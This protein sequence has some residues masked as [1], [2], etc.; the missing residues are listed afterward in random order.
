M[1][2]VFALLI[3]S[4]LLFA[5][6]ILDNGPMILGATVILMVI[7][8]ACCN[9]LANM[10]NM[11][12]LEAWVKTEVREIIIAGILFA[13]VAAI[14]YPDI[15]PI[16]TVLTAGGT[17]D[18]RTDINTFTDGMLATL[19]QA[20]YHV[21]KMSHYFT[22]RA[23]MAVSLNI[24]IYY[25]GLTQSG[26]PGAGYGAF[27]VP[28]SHAA[29]ALSN[30][31]Y[32]YKIIKMLNDFFLVICPP[33]LP[34]A[35][36]FRFIPFTRQLGNT[37]IALILGAYI[38]Y[39]ASIILVKD[40]HLMIDIPTPTVSDS[41]YGTM[42]AR[43]PGIEGL[44]FIC[45]RWYMRLLAVTL[46]ELGLDIIVC[47]PVAIA[48]LGAGWEPCKQIIENI[49]WPI[50]QI[51]LMVYMDIELILAQAMAGTGLDEM[52]EAVFTFSKATTQL[53]LV[54]YIDA[55]IIGTITISGTRSIASALGGEY[56]LGSI[57]R[58]V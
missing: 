32:I 34:I 2:L 26:T 3:L 5:A 47:I 53:V 45:G 27:L 40:F 43:A 37:L 17:S 28:L 35:F 51:L 48:T 7:V 54:T 50:I 41:D 1:K 12:G 4:G 56:F 20:Y 25:F 19:K 29:G 10:L 57:S 6:G 30:G 21:I 58:L 49:V 55:I 9:M 42:S 44:E 31:I 38:L 39:P 16:A 24:P 14:V 8:L 46:G 15:N 11:P 33:L 23:G 18:Y 52:F 36:A 13:I 22:M